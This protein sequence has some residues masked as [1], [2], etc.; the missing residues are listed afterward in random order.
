LELELVIFAESTFGVRR[1]S[2]PATALWISIKAYIR[3]LSKAP[4]ALRSAG[5]LQNIS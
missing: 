1:Q 2:A 5:A 3:N 4:S